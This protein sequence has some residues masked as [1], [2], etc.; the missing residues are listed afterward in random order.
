[1]NLIENACKYSPEG[2]EIHVSSIVQDG[3]AVMFVRDSGIGFPMEYRHKVFL[4]F[5]R[6]VGESTFP[7]TGIGLANAKRIVSRHGGK[8]WAESIVGKGSTFFFTL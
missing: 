5:E 4:P 2:G 6:L 8:I 3:N 7:G 1:M